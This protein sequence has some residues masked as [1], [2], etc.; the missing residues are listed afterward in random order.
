MDNLCEAYTSLGEVPMETFLYHTEYNPYNLVG[1]Q[2]PLD[3]HIYYSVLD[4]M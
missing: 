2:H 4:C 1:F 3:D